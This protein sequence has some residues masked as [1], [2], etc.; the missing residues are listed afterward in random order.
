MISQER[1]DVRIVGCTAIIFARIV[2]LTACGQSMCY[3]TFHL[4]IAVFLTSIEQDLI[5][6]LYLAGFYKQS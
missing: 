1:M 4:L 6:I 2:Y 5:V 3:L